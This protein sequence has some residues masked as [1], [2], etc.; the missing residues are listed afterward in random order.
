MEVDIPFVLMN[1][2]LNSIDFK[3]ENSLG[4]EEITGMT[5]GV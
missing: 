1:V 4:M 2:D 3:S 5:I